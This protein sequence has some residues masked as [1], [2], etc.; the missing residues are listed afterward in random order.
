MKKISFI[1]W[2]LLFAQTC[3]ADNN[4]VGTWEGAWYNDWG[5][6]EIAIS[7]ANNYSVVGTWKQ[8]LAP[9][10]LSGTV[11]VPISG[12]Y[13]YNDNNSYLTFDCGGTTTVQGYYVIYTIDGAGYITGDVANGTC[14]GTAYIYYNGNL[15][16]TDS[17]GGT[18]LLTRT[19]VPSK[20]TNPSPSNGNTNQSLTVGLSWSNGGGATSYNVYFGT[21]N[22]PDSGEFKGNQ[23]G[24]TYNPGTLSYNTTYYWRID[25]M[26]SNG[27]TTGDVWSFMTEAAPPQPPSKA[28]NPSP[29]NGTT[30]QS[31][32]V[33]TSWSNGG[34]ATS[35]DVYFGTDPTPDSGEYKGNQS[36]TSHAPGTLAYSAT[37]YWRIDA[38]NSAGTT[39]GNIWSFTIEAESILSDNFN[40]NAQDGLLW[41]R[42]LEDYTNCWASEIN[43]R[44]E[45]RSTGNTNGIERRAGYLSVGWLLDTTSDFSFKIDYHY[46]PVTLNDGGVLL[47]LTPDPIQPDSKHVEISAGCDENS[48]YFYYELVD[49]LG[50]DYDWISRSS[51][52]GTLYISY[53]AA[54][55][56]L[57][58]SY[59]GYGS[60]NTW[61]TIPDL[62]QGDWCGDPVYIGFGGYSTNVSMSSSVAYVDNFVMNTG[63]TTTPILLAPDLPDFNGDY[64]SDL[65][66]LNNSAQ[67]CVGTLMDGLSRIQ[68]QGLGGSDQWKIVGL[69][70]FDGDGKSDLLWREASTGRYVGTLMDGLSRGQDQVLG[71]SDQW[72]IVGLPDFDGDGKSDLLW[73]QTSTGRYVGTLMNGLSRGQDQ[74]LGGSSA[75]KIVGLPDFNGDGRSDLLWRETS[76]GR[77]VG[78]LMNGLSRGQ[79]Q[80]LGGSDAWKIVGLPDFDG[81]GKSDLLWRETST[82]RYVGTL[83]NGLSRV[84][85]QGLGGS[86]QWKIVELPDFDGDGKSDLLWRETS[87]GRY[88]GT[89]MNSLSRGQNQGLGGSDAW[90]IVELPDFDGDGKSDLLWRETSTGRYVGSLMNGLSRGQN[91]SLGGSDQW[92]IIVPKSTVP[93]VK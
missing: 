78:T 84:Q 12:I 70:D 75:W 22:T 57:Y 42:H 83:M 15:V 63:T 79:D 20:A 71:G 87:T 48:P 25:A 16:L 11:T 37:Y 9:W 56:E 86:D 76:T 60:S 73:R 39:T 29:S 7:Q 81:D 69:P 17:L 90:Q 65:L 4:P 33:N 51:N 92:R 13:T 82:G 26:N 31:I 6:G 5:G 28:T 52:D 2:F 91:Q 24:K 61:Q 85:D 59:T 1:I 53:N 89:L 74:A 58:L 47:G 93:A 10:G 80:A 27:T 19:S 38:K 3:I 34:G 8:P 49:E 46:S 18:W 30:N 43:Q 77:Y 44:L 64:N 50:A 72:Q 21:D 32:N 35:Y 36:G 67:K 88:V 41:Q 14:W 23:P 66:W 54:A 45:V 68:D 55:D 62:L 40:D